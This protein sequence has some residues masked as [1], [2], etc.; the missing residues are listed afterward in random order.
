MSL[1]E[2]D[3]FDWNEDHMAGSIEGKYVLFEDVED[4]LEDIKYDINKLFE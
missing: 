2:L 4:L 3:R 1:N